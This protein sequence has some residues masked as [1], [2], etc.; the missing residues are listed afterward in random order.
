MF[1]Y[2]RANVKENN[3]IGSLARAGEE[4]PPS[5]PAARVNLLFTPLL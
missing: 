3:H 4:R 5:F 2:S 1:P